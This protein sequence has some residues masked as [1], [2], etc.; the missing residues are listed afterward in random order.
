MTNSVYTCDDYAIENNVLTIWEGKEI[1][2]VKDLKGFKTIM[3]STNYTCIVCP[4]LIN[5]YIDIII[6]K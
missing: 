3:N 6:F 4:N 1:A 2:K 5:E